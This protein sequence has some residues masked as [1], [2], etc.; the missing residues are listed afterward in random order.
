MP[1]HFDACMSQLEARSARE[2]GSS[3]SSGDENGDHRHGKDELKPGREL[4]AEKERV[5]TPKH[6]A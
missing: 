2:T 6:H 3:Q 1:N 5:K 4:F